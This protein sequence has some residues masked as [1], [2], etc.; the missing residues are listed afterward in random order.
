MLLYHGSTVIV[1]EPH[2]INR[3]F[4]L[5]FGAGFYTTSSLE[6]AERW[7]RIKMKRGKENTGY[8]S[9]YDFDI[10][11]AHKLLAIKRFETADEE[12]LNF[13]VSC[14]RGCAPDDNI[15]IHIGPVAN[16][17]IFATIKLFETGAYDAEYT[18]KQLRT[19][20]LHDQWVFHTSEALQ[21][22]KFRGFKEINAE[23]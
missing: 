11:E 5:D 22:C 8:V 12:W 17:K 7:A 10:D 9:S 4:S 23:V 16:D 13:V 2:I 18:I 15:S 1:D 20:Q 6:Q 3:D 21:L 14:R 19:A